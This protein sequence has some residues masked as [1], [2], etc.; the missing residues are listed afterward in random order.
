MSK[1]I[2]WLM[3]GVGGLLVMAVLG[4]QPDYPIYDLKPIDLYLQLANVD[5]YIAE[6][7]AKITDLK[8]DN[9]AKV[10]W[11]NDSVQVTEYA[12]V[13][14]HGFSSSQGEGDPVH[15]EFAHRYGM[16]LYLSRL[17]DHGRSSEDSFKGLTP[18]DLI[19]S[20]KE[21]IAIGATIGKK[22]IVMSCS[23]GGTYSA[24]LA[25]SDSRIHA[26]LM[27]SPN[28][29]LADP[30]AKLI[31]YPWGEYILKAV[32]GDNHNRIQYTPAAQ[33]YWNSCYHTDGIIALQALLDDGM[34][35]EYFQDITVPTLVGC[36]YKNATEQDHVIS[37]DAAKVFFANIGTSD[38]LKVYKDFPEAGRHVF[39]S[40]I[41]VDDVSRVQQISY[42]FAEDVLQLSPID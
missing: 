19:T 9:E 1:V 28:I 20:A 8:P 39:T 40:H 14:L 34:K 25:P 30:N 37:V 41:M 18:K 7:E 15:R 42:E 38:D 22:V 6:Q 29:E 5:D 23:T 4:P 36:Y 26:M 2:K 13:Y 32:L 33:Q 12:L 31:T 35:D 10:V 11:Y 27:Y 16:N 3:I 17:A 21:A 24:M